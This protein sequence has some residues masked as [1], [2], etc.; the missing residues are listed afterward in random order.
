MSGAQKR[1]FCGILFGLLCL[2]ALQIWFTGA[3][4]IAR[5]EGDMLHLS[6]LILRMTSGQLPHLDYMTPIGDLA[7]RPM[8]AIL[9]LQKRFD[10]N[11]NLGLGGAMLWGQMLVAVAVFPAVCWAGISR[12]SFGLATAFGI[13]VLGL[14]TALVFGGVHTNLSLSMHYNRWAWALT[15]LIVVLVA[16]PARRDRADVWDGLIIGL[17][18][19]ALAL[20]KASYA[21]A[22]VLPVA[23]GL[24]IQFRARVAWVGIVAALAVWGLY[25]WAIGIEFWRAYAEDLLAVL[26]SDIRPFPSEPLRQV[27]LSPAFTPATIAG[28]AGGLLLRRDSRGPGLTLLMF[29]PAFA[30]IA[31]QNYGNDPL[32]LVPLAVCLIAQLPAPGEGARAGMAG[33]ALAAVALI[34]SPMGNILYSP[35]RHALQPA[36]LFSP[37]LPGADRA[38]LMILTQR[39][40]DP[41]V[42]A[43]MPI[44]GPK[45]APET[46][47]GQPLGDCRLEGGLVAVL[48][49]QAEAMV[50]QGLGGGPQPFV[51][52]FFAP[53]WMFADLTPLPGAAP[54]YY[55]G[56]PGFDAATHVMV[57]RCPSK[58]KVRAQIL[59]LITETG[60]TLSDIYSDDVMTLYE[61]AR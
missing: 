59:S 14:I 24:M 3:F 17:A 19:M 6:E 55:T 42:Q 7:I 16:I 33:V 56:L 22:L 8:A 9:D 25:S 38:D 48:R 4:R 40:T 21:V 39:T 26:N 23:F 51:A 11:T 27:V 30:Y 45:P 43:P 15:F 1:L 61:I 35:I 46:F 52:D 12:M 32:W 2:E 20:I 49:A 10:L 54:W 58:P 5:H 34:A 37:M 50:A 29:L 41:Y 53:H 18:M 28:L 31:F 36:Q 13:A 47:Q 57:P 60:V 44:D